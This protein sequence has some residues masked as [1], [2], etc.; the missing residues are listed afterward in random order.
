MKRGKGYK[1]AEGGKATTKKAQQFPAP[2]GTKPDMKQYNM[3][4]QQMLSQAMRG[5]AQADQRRNDV[6]PQRDAMIR[7][8]MEGYRNPS[9]E[10]PSPEK[11]RRYIERLRNEQMDKKMNEG[12]QKSKSRNFQS[13]GGVKKPRTA[14]MG[15]A[16]RNE[17]LLGDK[18]G[19][20]FDRDMKRRVMNDHR[21]LDTLTRSMKQSANV[22]SRGRMDDLLEAV[23]RG[24]SIPKTYGS[25]YNSRE[26]SRRM[27]KNEG[28]KPGDKLSPKERNRLLNELR[29]LRGL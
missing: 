11:M 2:A 27:L 18:T 21:H 10:Q 15:E 24:E 23:R 14:N 5:Q 16:Y 17:Y 12:Y 26:A 7:K 22:N 6:N 28:V 13:G 9:S 20:E 8:L 29:K 1:F 4:L 25:V 3:A 19:K